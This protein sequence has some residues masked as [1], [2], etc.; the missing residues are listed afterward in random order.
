MARRE[1][2]DWDDDFFE[3]MFNEFGFD[4]KRMNER[5]RKIWE[6]ML[7]NPDFGNQNPYVYGFT[8]K[9]GPEGKPY[10]QEFG[11]L[12]GVSGGR[13][14]VEEQGV[15]EPI[16]DINED[17][18]KVYFT[19]ELPGIAKE[20]IDLKVSPT[21]VTIAVKEGTRKYHKS[22]DLEYEIKQDSTK[23]KFVNGILDV[24]IEKKSKEG[25]GK[26]IRIE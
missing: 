19:F 10:F 24:A 3:D 22:I 25:T 9:M 7:Q 26:T 18:D 20:N 5:M 12:P 23:A 21:N 2:D 16:T 8:Y 14:S 17:K 1:H 15:R 11:N 6:K 4:F 13:A